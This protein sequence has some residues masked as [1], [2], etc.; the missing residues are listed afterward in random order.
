[1]KE[2][3]EGRLEEGSVVA[4]RQKSERMRAWGE[5]ERSRGI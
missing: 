1:M 5:R 2:V 4:Q 3:A